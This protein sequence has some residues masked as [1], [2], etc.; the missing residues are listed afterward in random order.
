MVLV[1][2]VIFNMLFP[3]LFEQGYANCI[4]F[5]FYLFLYIEQSFHK[6]IGLILSTAVNSLTSRIIYLDFSAMNP[7]PPEQWRHF[8]K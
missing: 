5:S 3:A 7:I 2:G 8:R 6:N 4:S 1:K